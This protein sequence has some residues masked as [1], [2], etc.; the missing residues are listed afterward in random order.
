MMAIARDGYAVDPMLACGSAN[1]P[2]SYRYLAVDLF[3]SGI[4]QRRRRRSTARNVAR[5]T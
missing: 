3:F 1:S 2:A 5:R 4:R